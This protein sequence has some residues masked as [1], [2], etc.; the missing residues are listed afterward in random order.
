MSAH[1]FAL[2]VAV[3]SEHRAVEALTEVVDAVFLPVRLERR[4]WSDRIKR[5]E[6]PLFPGYC[7]VRVDLTA[8]SRIEL[9]RVKGVVDVVGRRPGYE[10]IATSV[11]D[12]E[13]A[14]LQQLVASERALDPLATLVA[15]AA[16]L[17][18]A[19]PLK[20]VR[21]VVEQSVDGQRRIVV[22]VTLLGRAVRTTLQADDLLEDLG[23]C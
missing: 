14:S 8:A 21:G 13:I 22:N 3:R 1:W 7:F 5:T 6:V 23:G 15:G 17:V 11:P 4:A 10:G 18:G 20:G 16:V 19:G 12:Q 9:L 2:A